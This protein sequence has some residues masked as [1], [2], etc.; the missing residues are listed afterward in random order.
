MQEEILILG[1][2]PVGRATTQ[3][4]LASGAEVRVAQRSRPADLPAGVAF[5]ACDVLDPAAVTV[6]FKGAAQVVVSIG[7]AYDGAVWQRDWPRAMA[8]LLD[9][10]AATRTRIVFLDNLYM[11]GAQSAPLTED[12]PLAGK[13]RKPAARAA[14]T[15][16]W[17]AAAARGEVRFA[18]LR[19]PDFYGPGTP[20]SHLGDTA[21]GALARGKA[22]QLLM[23]PDTPHDFAYVPDIARAIL[24]L[25]DAP[26]ADFNQVWNMPCAPTQTPR[27]ILAA[28]FPR[29]RILAVPL[30]LQPLLGLALPFVRELVEMRF[31]FDRP[32]AV[33][34][35][36]F[37]TRFNFTPT[38]FA[39]GARQTAAAFANAPKVEIFAASRQNAALTRPATA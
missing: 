9:A 7:F 29:P 24:L 1:Y 12:M 11:L 26:D 23:H 30:R 36:K 32:Y 27:Q 2:G 17:Q 13:A 8:N 35:R 37:T 3:H 15:R 10:A 38:A 39:E 18:A 19:A 33:D 14:I 22:A 34:A 20:L 5:T 4:L 28:G 6:A 16:Q 25:L 31:Q 21:F